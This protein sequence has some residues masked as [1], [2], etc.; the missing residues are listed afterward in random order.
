[1]NFIYTYSEEVKNKLISNGFTFIR[2]VVYGNKQAFLFANN[3]SKL[4]FNQG[5]VTYSNK[6]TF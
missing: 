1:M 6:L 2:K 5:E 3:G 4:T